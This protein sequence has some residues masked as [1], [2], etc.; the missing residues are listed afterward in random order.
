[1]DRCATVRIPIPAEFWMLCGLAEL[2]TVVGRGGLEPPTSALARLEIE[3][4]ATY[5][6][7]L[8]AEMEEMRDLRPQQCRIVG[9]GHEVDATAVRDPGGELGV[10]GTRH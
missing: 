10:S 2:E 9:P 4:Q 3:E 5:F 1:M 6:G 8:R 7:L